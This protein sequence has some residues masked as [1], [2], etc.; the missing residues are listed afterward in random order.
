MQIL[1]NQQ[2][3]LLK[4]LRRTGNKMI[5]SNKV[6]LN[7]IK[8]EVFTGSD[9]GMRYRLEK[10]GDNILVN[11]WPEPYCFLK[12]DEAMKVSETFPLSPEGKEEAVAWL[13][14]QEELR[15]DIWDSVNRKPLGTIM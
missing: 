11:A 9:E 14:E 1:E 2:S 7:F 15:R 3:G 8:K 6:S 12:T 5:D 13:N 10:S 4:C